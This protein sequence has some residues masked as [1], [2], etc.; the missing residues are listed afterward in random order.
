MLMPQPAQQQG[1]AVLGLPRTAEA[2]LWPQPRS[3]PQ[4]E[5]G[6]WSEK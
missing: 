1:W 4:S 6:C 3:R 2:F 5:K